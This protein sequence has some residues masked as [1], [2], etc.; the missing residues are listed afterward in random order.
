MSD[1]QV[2]AA[3]AAE[4]GLDRDAFVERVDA[5]DCRERLAANTGELIERGGFGTPTVFVDQND[6]FFG[7]DRL[8][9][10]REAL[11]RPASR[12]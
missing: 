12:A 4:A 10:V 8:D 3:L 7:N 6:M 9:F 2:L 11:L 1:P 5:T